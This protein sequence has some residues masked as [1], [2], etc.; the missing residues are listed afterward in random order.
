MLYQSIQVLTASL[1]VLPLR[2]WCADEQ[3]DITPIE[4]TDEKAIEQDMLSSSR[5]SSDIEKND[6][7][8]EN[9]A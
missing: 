8:D 4:S 5:G 3:P 9:A 7:I 6:C 2:K 1:L